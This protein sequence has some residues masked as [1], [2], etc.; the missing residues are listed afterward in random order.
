MNK[1]QYW[2]TYHDATNTH[3]TYRDTRNE[4]IACF[5]AYKANAPRWWGIPCVI[6]LASIGSNGTRELLARKVISS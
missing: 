1:R 6:K 2:I 3:G 4:A 5:E